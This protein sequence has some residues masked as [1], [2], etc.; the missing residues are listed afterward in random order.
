M[1]ESAKIYEEEEPK[2]YINLFCCHLSL[3]IIYTLL[4]VSSAVFLNVINRVIFY[5]YHF[6]QYNF[7]FM[8][9]QQLFCIVFFLILSFK[10][11][12]FKAKAG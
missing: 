10:S 12:T 8:L 4:Y 7:T 2:E 11:Q 6:N 5:T 9:M 1:S 3:N